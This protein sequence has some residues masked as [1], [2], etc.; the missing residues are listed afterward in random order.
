MA[1]RN[2]PSDQANDEPVFVA[3]LDHK[4]NWFVHARRLFLDNEY[5]RHVREAGSFQLALKF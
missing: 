2:A 5:K 3:W 4:N 1:D